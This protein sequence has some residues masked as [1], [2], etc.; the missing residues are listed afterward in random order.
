MTN[1]SEFKANWVNATKCSAMYDHLEDELITS[2][3]KVDYVCPNVENITLL[4]Y[5]PLYQ[6]GNGTSFSMVVNS[7][8]EAKRIEEEYNLTPYNNT[9]ECAST[10]E[11]EAMTSFFS[12]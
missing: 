9:V 2:E 6:N 11:I 12:L 4:N 8:I 3:E 5:P 1:G 10:E 7:C